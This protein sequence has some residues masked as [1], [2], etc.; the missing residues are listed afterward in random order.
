MQQK[1][2]PMPIHLTIH[3]KVAEELKRLMKNRYLERA[4]EITEDFF[5]S[6]SVITVKKTNQ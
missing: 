1:G 5:A 3:D 6:P 2:R 4:T